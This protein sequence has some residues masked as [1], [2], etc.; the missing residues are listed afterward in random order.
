MG[1]DYR[2]PL[3]GSGWRMPGVDRLAGGSALEGG[4]AEGE[5]AAVSAGQPV[6]LAGGGAVDAHD[7]RVGVLGRGRSEVFG[8]TE[9]VDA[10][11]RSGQPVAEAF[12]RGRHAD[13]RGVDV[14]GRGR[15][16]VLGVAVGV[17]TAVA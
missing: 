17:D 3:P 15:S 5:D 10:A 6:S 16:E 1:G 13:D 9:G 14:V 2:S 4:V 7:R 11:V 12:G 8:V